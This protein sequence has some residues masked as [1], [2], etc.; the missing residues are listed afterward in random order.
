MI[1]SCVPNVRQGI[2]TV[3]TG[4]S[5]TYESGCPLNRNDTSGFTAAVNAAKAAD[6]VVL[7]MGIDPSMEG[8]DRDRTSIDL[9]YIQHQLIAAIVAVHKPTVLVLLNG[10]MVSIEAEKA[11]VPAIIEA[12]Y[13]GVLGAE[14]I[15]RTIFGQND[16]L[17]GKLP[18][19]IYPANYVNQVKMSY[20]ELEP[21]AGVS[22]GRTYRFYTG[23]VVYPF[24]HGLT[25][26]TFKV[27]PI[28]CGNLPS[29]R[30]NSVA[31]LDMTFNIANTGSRTGDEVIMAYVSPTPRHNSKVIKKLIGYKRVHL[32]INEEA[33]LTFN[34]NLSHLQFY[35]RDTLANDVLPGIY[36][37]TFT[38][39]VE[40]TFVCPVNVV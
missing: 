19:T 33:A 25:Y 8:E 10:G 35:D 26:T 17:G 31:G 7:V 12:G 36:P 11:S 6:Y 28:A 32:E 22:P 24:G 1:F 39:G 21:K 40:T 3:N 18:Y 2:Q 37:I 27:T 15:A 29:L 5:V 34:L 20:M 13:P 9:P 14:A 4:G 23:P 16:H 30:L 38:N